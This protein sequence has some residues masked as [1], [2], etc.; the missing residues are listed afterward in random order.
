[1]IEENKAA[2]DKKVPAV[3]GSTALAVVEIDEE[4]RGA[5]L[6]NITNDERKVPF[7]RILQ[8]NSP[9]LEEGNSKYMPNAKA[10]MFMNSSTKQLYRSL[11]MVAC[12]RDHKFIEYTPRAIGGGF[13]ALHKPGDDLIVALRAQHGKFGKLPRNVTRRDKDGQALDGTEIVESFELYAI[14]IDPETGAKFRAIVPFQSTQ[15]GKYQSFIDRADSIE[16]LVAGSDVPVKPALYSHRWLLTTGNEKNKK[17]AFKG[18]VIGLAEKKED[19]S[20]DLPIKSFVKRSDPLFALAKEFAKFVEAGKADV[21][22]GSTANEEP[23][24]DADEVEM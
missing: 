24:K 1:M 21:D 3:A 9:E 23:P 14:L 6:R 2:D 22:Y 16:Y 12:G 5:G 17:G 13:V 8:S 4:D 19:G 15:I 18:Y 11:Q 7:L 20:D 10:G